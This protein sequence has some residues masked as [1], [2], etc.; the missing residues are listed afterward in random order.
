MNKRG[1]FITEKST[2][3][4][5]FGTNPLKTMTEMKGQLKSNAGDIEG[6]TKVTSN[7]PNYT[8]FIPK[9]DGNE[10]ATMQA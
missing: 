9:Y 5:T 8:G 4:G 3:Y 6:T 1:Q 7:P 2:A 10:I